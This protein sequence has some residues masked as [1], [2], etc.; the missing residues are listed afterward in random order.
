MRKSKSCAWSMIAVSG[1]ADDIP[2]DGAGSRDAARALVTA[3]FIVMPF[4]L[5][6]QV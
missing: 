1:V 3:G 5:R 2:I 6:A 4:G